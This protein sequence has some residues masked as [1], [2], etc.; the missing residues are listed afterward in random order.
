M[1]MKGLFI[2]LV[3]VNMAFFAWRYNLEEPGFT[4]P[5]QENSA[6]N[7]KRLVLLREL[8][9]EMAKTNPAEH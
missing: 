3:L 1:I 5:A 6:D 4:P 2:F 8:D 9:A 7:S